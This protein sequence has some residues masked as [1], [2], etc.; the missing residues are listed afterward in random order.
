MFS[1]LMN[2]FKKIKQIAKHVLTKTLQGEGSNLKRKNLEVF[3][4][5]K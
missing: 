1:S 3:T 2:E 5:N 4:V